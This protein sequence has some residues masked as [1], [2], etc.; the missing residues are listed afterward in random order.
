MCILKI[1]QHSKSSLLYD[2]IET[3]I[4]THF[5]DRRTRLFEKLHYDTWKVVYLS[6]S[7]VTPSDSLGKNKGDRNVNVKLQL[8]ETYFQTPVL[9]S[10]STYVLV[11]WAF[12][13][14]NSGGK[15]EDSARQARMTQN[16]SVSCLWCL[17]NLL[18]RSLTDI[19]IF[20][21]QRSNVI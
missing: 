19:C 9:A 16:M 20:D 1:V 10:L 21:G 6:F 7:S 4:H 12:V 13:N 11:H 14:V 3:C 8:F 17:E 18:Y 2:N 5:K 15:V